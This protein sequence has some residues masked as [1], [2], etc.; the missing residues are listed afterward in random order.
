MSLRKTLFVSVLILSTLSLAAGYGI[1]HQW[2]GM[3]AALLLGPVWWFARK[4]PGPG[5]PFASLSFAVGLAVIGKLSGSPPVWMIVGSTAALAAWDLLLLDSALGNTVPGVAA[6]QYENR[7]LWTLLLA[8]GLALLATLLGRSI[9]IQLP[10]VV[11][12]L[13]LAFLLF[14]LDRVWNILNK[15]AR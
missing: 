11:L 15:R 5:M 1:A 8:L 14:A 7:H 3:I 12:L 4:H 2:M 6:R 10:F 13:S 9:T